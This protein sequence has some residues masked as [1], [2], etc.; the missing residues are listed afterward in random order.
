[1]PQYNPV[2]RNKTTS[3]SYLL[4]LST[5][6][7]YLGQMEDTTLAFEL[8]RGFFK[9]SQLGPFTIPLLYNGLFKLNQKQEE[10]NQQGL[11]IEGR[12]PLRQRQTKKLAEIVLEIA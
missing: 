2:K 5:K 9:N 12:P 11:D 6:W 1:M 8:T 10:T 7:G 4:A 3:I